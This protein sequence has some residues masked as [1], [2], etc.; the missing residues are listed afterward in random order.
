MIE[1][2]GERRMYAEQRSATVYVS[3]HSSPGVVNFL[4]QWTEDGGSSEAR[5]NRQPPP[6]PRDPVPTFHLLSDQCVH[7]TLLR[8]CSSVAWIYFQQGMRTEL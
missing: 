5:E 8:G 2:D 4:E 3:Q 6:L 1:Y 7:Q